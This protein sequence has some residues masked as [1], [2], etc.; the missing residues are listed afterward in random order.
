[1]SRG[2]RSTESKY[3]VSV[4]H[5][6]SQNSRRRSYSLVQVFCTPV[7]D[8]QTC[9]VLFEKSQRNSTLS[10]LL[11]RDTTLPLLSIFYTVFNLYGMLAADDEFIVSDSDADLNETCRSIFCHICKYHD[12]LVSLTLTT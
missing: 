6:Y 9:S 7:R 4:R 2:K 3:Y 8:L 11:K 10:F 5:C 12:V 1:M